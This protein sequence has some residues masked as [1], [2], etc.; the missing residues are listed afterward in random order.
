MVNTMLLGL[1]T[2]KHLNLKNSEDQMIPTLSG[3]CYAVQSMFHISK[4][5]TP[6]PVYFTY[7]HSITEF[8]GVTS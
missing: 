1:P 2:D 7:F 3:T 4:I 8:L 5:N 6:K